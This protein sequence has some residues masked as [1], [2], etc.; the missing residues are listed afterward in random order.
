M[1]G[2]DLGQRL[3]SLS[4]K[5]RRLLELRLD[6]EQTAPSPLPGPSRPCRATAGRSRSPSPSSGSGSSTS[7]SPAAPAY[8]MPVRPAP[9][10]PA[11]RRRAGG[12]PGRDRAPP[13]GRCA[14]PS[15]LAGGRAGP[16]RSRR[17]AGLPLPRGRPRAACRAAAREAEAAAPRR[18]RGAAARSTSRAGP[19]LRA[20]LLRARRRTST[21]CSSTMHHIVSD[22]WSMGVL[23]RELAALYARLRRRAGRRRSPALP[24]QYA[25]FAVWQRALAAGRGARARSSPTGA[26]G[27]PGA[28]PLLELPTDRPRPAGRRPSAARPLP[29]ALPPALAAALAALGRRAGRDAV[30]DPARR[31]PGAARA[32]TP[33][34]TTSSVGTPI[35][36]RNRA[37][38]R[39]ADRLLRQHPG[40]ARRP[41]AATRPSA[42]CWRGC[43]RPRSAPTPTRTCPSSSWSRSCAPEREP[44]AHAALPGDVRAAERAARRRLEP[45]GPRRS[46]RSAAEQRHRQVRPHADLWPRRGGGLAGALEL[47]HRPLRRRHRSRR[48]A[49]HFATL[50]DGGRRRAR[51]RRLA[52]CRCWPR[53]SASSCCVEWNDTGA[54]A[55]P[56]RRCLHELFE[57]QAARTPGRR[58]RWSPARSALTYGELDAPGQP[59][60]PPPARPGRRARG[61]GSASALERSPRAGR[62]AARRAQG[63]RRLRAARPGLPAR[64]PGASCWR[65]PARA[66]L[67]TERALARSLPAAAGAALCL[68]ADRR[69]GGERAGG[70]RRPVAATG[71]PRLRDLHLGLDRPAQG[72]GDR[73]PQRRRP[74]APGRARS[75]RRRTL[76][77]VLAST[78]LCFDLS[79]FEIF[80][81]LCLR[82]ARWS[83]PTNALAL[84]RAAGGRA[85]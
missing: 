52:S 14:P 56:A 35:A 58:G 23:V 11:R 33:A 22:G 55:I 16:G 8:N 46:R 63:R 10:R 18:G 7:S 20:A 77:G 75:S 82:A 27:S 51:R 85:R 31:L 84:P 60:G 41:R 70:R 21:R 13:R 72:R 81:P 9:R 17:A 40:P 76:A 26:S 54:A 74:R 65:T 28:P 2:A 29:V 44:G 71:Q 48:L 49:G 4:P 19:L 36:N 57:A 42:S 68:D 38:D 25:D 61:A 50:L 1:S 78:S 62:G 43:A 73:A 53:P 6:R 15:P 30:H 80:V 12:G 24:V 83:W 66:V 59:A 5:Q 37:G 45:A 32:A 47:Q 64:A 69:A 34:R 39:G 79:V 3:E 67:V